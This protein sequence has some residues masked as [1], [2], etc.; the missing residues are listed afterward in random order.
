MY[1]YGRLVPMTTNIRRTGRDSN[2]AALDPLVHA[3]WFGQ[4][5]C[6]CYRP[7]QFTETVFR[8]FI[9][10]HL[11]SFFTGQSLWR[12]LPLCAECSKP[13][14]LAYDWGHCERC[15][16]EVAYQRIVHTHSHNDRRHERNLLIE[17]GLPV[18]HGKRVHMFCGERCA[19]KTYHAK[20]QAKRRRKV[21]DGR[22]KTCDVCGT[23]FEGRANAKT[24]SA[25]CR[26]RRSRRQVLTPLSVTRSR[27]TARQVLTP[28]TV[29]QP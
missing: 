23:T 28:L 13:G 14:H 25:K 11:K 12:L 29:T 27:S 22:R 9:T 7:I 16:R 26:K 15:G 5:C 1:E 10:T 4:N 21:A 3:K 24:C 6:K 8:T 19:S 18:H 2:P 20:E 17:A